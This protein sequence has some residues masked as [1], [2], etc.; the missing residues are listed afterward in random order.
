MITKSGQAFLDNLKYIEDNRETLTGYW[1]A[2]ENGILI[3]KDKKLLTL[4]E[5]LN[6]IGFLRRGVLVTKV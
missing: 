6:L 5:R 4:R 3:D 1:V 2:L